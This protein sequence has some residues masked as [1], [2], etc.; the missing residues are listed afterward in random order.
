M[1]LLKEELARRDGDGVLL[2]QQPLRL[3]WHFSGMPTSDGHRIDCDAHC[4]VRPADNPVDIRMLREVLLGTQYALGTGDV[5]K[6]FQGKLQGVVSAVVAESTA[7]DLLNEAGRRALADAFKKCAHEIAFSCGLEVLAPFD[8]ETRSLTVQ[9]ERQARAQRQLAE[10]HAS[11][12]IAHLQR[13]ADLLRQ[14]ESLRQATPDLSPSRLLEQIT[15][16]DRGSALQTLLLA[17]A[18]QGSTQQLWAVA[19]P[20]L[21]KVDARVRPMRAELKQLPSTMG[22]L[23]SVQATA[24]GRLMVGAQLGFFLHDPGSAADPLAYFLPGLQSPLGFNAVSEWGNAGYAAT[25][26]QAGLVFW[27]SNRPDEPEVNLPLDKLHRSAESASSPRNLLAWDE[28]QM[29]LSVGGRALLTDSA[30]VQALPGA[31]SSEII[32]ILPSAL[33][34]AVVHQDGTIAYYDRH[35]REL[36]RHERHGGHFAAAAAM[37]WLGSQRLLLASDHGPMVCVGCEDALVTQFVSA[38]AGFKVVCAA[39]DC[40][41]ALSADRQRLIAWNSWDGKTPTGELH[42]VALTRHRVAD[43]AFA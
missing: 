36:V 8:I 35:T 37:P 19:G 4:S 27:K 28:E 14:F 6:H 25:H 38:H 43:I 40:V 17:S 41:V 9:Q 13:S 22:P 3:T 16:A 23:R 29:V 31:S 39:A 10:E 33:E 30:Q 5:R 15:P 11:G 1:A 7:N 2:A 21:L 42:V 26:G 12:K 24:A 32:A 34:M 18:Q 20:Y